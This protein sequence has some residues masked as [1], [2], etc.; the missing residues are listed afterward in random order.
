MEISGI[1]HALIPVSEKTLRR[2]NRMYP[3][4]RM[5]TLIKNKLLYVN[6]TLRLSEKLLS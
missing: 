4:G 1:L 3:M 2:I 6:L 5:R